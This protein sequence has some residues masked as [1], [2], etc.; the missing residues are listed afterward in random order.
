MPKQRRTGLFSATQTRKLEDLIRAGLRNP[1][2]VTV[3]EKSASG[4][5]SAQRTPTT[6]SNYYMVFMFKY[7]SV[8]ILKLTIDFSFIRYDIHFK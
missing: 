5:D 8:L 3:T 6:L 4:A 2:R 7:L 1:V